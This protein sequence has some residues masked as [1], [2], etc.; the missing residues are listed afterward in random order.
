[1]SWFLTTYRNAVRQ[2]YGWNVTL[3]CMKCASTN[4]PRYEGASPN[5]EMNAGDDVIIYARLA[6]PQCKKR[7]IDEAGN[8]LVELFRDVSI[9]EKNA[10][11]IRDF[12]ASLIMV[13]LT[14]AFTLFIGM[15]M[16]WWGNNAFALLVASSG[17]IPLLVMLMR[18][19]VALLRSRCS[20]GKPDYVIMGLLNN[21]ACYHCASCGKLLPLRD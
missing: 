15:R 17:L 5:N 2:R 4:M 19:R 14:L 7:L 16:G 6:C 8:K 3:T 12:I 20:C 9:P 13:P 10:R 1:M 18:Y 21:I 11:I